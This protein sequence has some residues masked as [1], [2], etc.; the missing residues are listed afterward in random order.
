ML[1]YGDNG[2][3]EEITSDEVEENIDNILE[4]VENRLEILKK[5]KF[6]EGD[7]EALINEFWEWGLAKQG[8]DIGYLYLP[9]LAELWLMKRQ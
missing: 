3:I 8:D 1:N 4:F 5:E 2:E 9:R 7:M 6:R